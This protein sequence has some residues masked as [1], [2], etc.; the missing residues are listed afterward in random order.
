VIVWFPGDAFLIF[1]L[2]LAFD[3][4]DWPTSGIT[5][6]ASAWLGAVLRPGPFPGSYRKRPK[7]DAPSCVKPVAL[8]LS[9]RC[10][11]VIMARYRKE[12][13][14]RRTRRSRSTVPVLTRQSPGRRSLG[15]AMRVG[16]GLSVA[17]ALLFIVAPDQ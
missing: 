7:N 13:L 4:P 1:H 14:W 12:L 15:S 3:T 10:A 9:A 17:V 8:R 11:L 5:H 16:I 6:A 2:Y